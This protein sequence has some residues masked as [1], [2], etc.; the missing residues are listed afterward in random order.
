ML[1]RLNNLGIRVE[2]EP[3][4]TFYVW[5]NL[6]ALPPTLRD[7][8]DFFEACL[9]QKVITVPG[10]FFDVNPEKRRVLARFRHYSRISFGPEMSA[11]ERG[12]DKLEQVISDHKQTTTET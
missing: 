10:V 7:G 2:A 6:S 11:L 3:S 4:G 9:K 1:E 12:L 5:A 8:F